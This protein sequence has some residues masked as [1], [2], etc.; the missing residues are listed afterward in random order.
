MKLMVTSLV[1]LMVCELVRSQSTSSQEVTCPTGCDC[2]DKRNSAGELYRVE[3]V[4]L[5]VTA[6]SDLHIPHVTTQ[7]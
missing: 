5:T 7:L 6:I 4:N 1:L 3:C 2:K